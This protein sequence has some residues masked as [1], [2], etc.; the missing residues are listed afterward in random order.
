MLQKEIKIAVV[1]NM[2]AGKSTFINAMFGND[3]LPSSSEAT[4]DCPIYIYSDNELN[5]NMAII[6]FHNKETKGLSEIN[7]RKELKEY[8]QK[9]S[10]VDNEK[11]K[12]VKKIDLY[13]RFY[14]KLFVN[15]NHSR[16]YFVLIDTPGPNNSDKF[17]EQHFLITQNIILGH[18]SKVIYLLDYKQI[19]ANLEVTKNNLWG[20]IEK[21]KKMDSEFEVLFVI[22]KSDKALDD[23]EKIQ[24]ILNADSEEEYISKIKKHWFFHEKKAIEKIE[25]LARKVGFIKPTILTISAE[26]IKLD[27][28]KKLSLYDKRKLKDFKDFFKN[29]FG[30][31]WEKKFHEY[32]GS[33]INIFDFLKNK[34]R[35]T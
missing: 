18:A 20:W 32:I 24:D 31:S 1:A 13:W 10:L 25:N 22:N 34:E 21:R 15:K 3:I 19:D 6:E 11:Y 8:A 26:Y 23:N 30:E 9:D 27:R 12:N 28:M 35:R 2:S 33:D 5:N 17:G 7:L 14:S 4:T 29:I 16:D